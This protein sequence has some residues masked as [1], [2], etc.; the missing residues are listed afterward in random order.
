MPFLIK[1][2]EKL[3]HVSLTLNC[4]VLHIY[5]S[6]APQSN[7]FY[8]LNIISQEFSGCIRF[9]EAGRTVTHVIRIEN[10]VYC[11]SWVLSL[12]PRAV[13]QQGWDLILWPMDLTCMSL[14]TGLNTPAMVLQ[15]LC[16]RQASDAVQTSIWSSHQAHQILPPMM[17]TKA[18][19]QES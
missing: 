17:H 16:L 6:H 7:P 5:R 8:G 3:E 10:S 4:T 13:H 12:V 18:F 9:V 2:L 1:C 11:P 14:N 19:F 15:N